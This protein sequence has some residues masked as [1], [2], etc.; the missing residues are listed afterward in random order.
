M[1]K[2]IDEP[3]KLKLDFYDHEEEEVEIVGR[4]SF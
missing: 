3:A 1:R 2:K 4:N